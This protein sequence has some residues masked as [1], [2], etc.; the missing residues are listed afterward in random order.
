M[1]FVRGREVLPLNGE[2]RF[3]MVS[4]WRLEMMRERLWELLVTD[5]VDWPAWWPH[6]ASVSSLASGDQDGIGSRHAF[7]WRSGLGYLLRIVMTTRR[8]GGSLKLRPAVTCTASGSRATIRGGQP[9]RS[10]P[11]VPLEN[12]HS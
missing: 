3:V 9:R 10:T 5:P 1:A 4:R 12:V 6:L 8:A 11:Y 7:L 2:P